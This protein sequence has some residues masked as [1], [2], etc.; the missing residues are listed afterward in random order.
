MHAPI[1]VDVVVVGAGLSGLQTAHLL[2]Q[3][4]YNCHVLEATA[5]V[6]GKTKSVKSKRRGPGVNDVGAAWIN[7]TTQSEM[8]KLFQ[9]YNI[10][11]EVQL[12]SGKSVHETVEGSYKA[13]PYGESPVCSLSRMSTMTF[14]RIVTTDHCSMTKPVEQSSTI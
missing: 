4:G 1:D 13:L 2:Q 10:E 8:Y 12:I 6:G 11:G 14:P 7:D 5:R 9:R 3:A